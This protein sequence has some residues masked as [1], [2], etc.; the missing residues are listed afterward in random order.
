VQTSTYKTSTIFVSVGRRTAVYH[1]MDDVPAELRD[2]LHAH[3]SGPNSRTL[4]VA[5]RRGREYL[6]QALRRAVRKPP[7]RLSRPE[8]M[9]SRPT[10]WWASA[11]QYWLEIGLI[12]FLGVASWTLLHWH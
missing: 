6:I 1:S 9:R 11:K 4:I 10:R 8:E 5:D 7:A 12:G 2:K 3:I